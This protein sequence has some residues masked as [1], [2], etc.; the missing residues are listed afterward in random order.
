MRG[1]RFD[2]WRGA[3]YDAEDDRDDESDVRSAEEEVCDRSP[4][5]ESEGP[6]CADEKPTN[7][8]S[9]LHEPRV[10]APVIAING[11]NVLSVDSNRMFYG[12]QIAVGEQARSKRRTPFV[13]DAAA[14]RFSR[15][16]LNVI[17]QATICPTTPSDIELPVMTT[18][19]VGA[20]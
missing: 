18:L 14:S 10:A 8:E 7:P 11:T 1:G 6:R 15:E 13:S 12:L 2:R 20:Y 9:K 3:D 5:C 19:S 16:L 4:R 17:V